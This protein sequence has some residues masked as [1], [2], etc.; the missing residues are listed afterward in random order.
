M[1][2]LEQYTPT[3]TIW[4]ATVVNS[5]IMDKIRRLPVGYTYTL[6]EEETITPDLLA[7]QILGKANYAWI[8]MIYNNFLDIRELSYS[9]G[10][11]TI[12]IPD[13]LS[14][15]NLISSIADEGE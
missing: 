5:V 3:S 9:Y 13:K 8:I 12:K 4:T 2:E 7:Y 6:D 10:T 15:I 11:R 14:L 1:P